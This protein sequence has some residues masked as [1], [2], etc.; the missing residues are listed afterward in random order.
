M[1]ARVII[2]ELGRGTSTR[3]GLAIALAVAEALA[4][5]QVRSSLHTRVRRRQARRL[6][7]PG[8]GMVRHPLQRSSRDS[9]RALRSGQPPP[10]CRGQSTFAPKFEFV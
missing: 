1:L 6:T 5:S 3:D 4:E 2:D 8:L 9:L 7:S 10:G